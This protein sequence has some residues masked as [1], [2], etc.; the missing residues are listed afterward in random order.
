MEPDSIVIQ[1]DKA[2]FLELGRVFKA[3]YRGNAAN[4]IFTL[5]QGLLR[6]EFYGGGCELPCDHSVDLVA[7]MTAKKFSG[8]MGDHRK[9]KSTTGLIEL[10]F[11]IGLCEFAT[12]ISGGKVKFHHVSPRS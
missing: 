2:K 9:E 12:P 8:I 10:T 3:A 6:I 11:R 1:V 7:E 5:K 4:V